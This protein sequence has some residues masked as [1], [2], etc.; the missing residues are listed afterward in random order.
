VETVIE[1]IRITISFFALATTF[2]LLSALR[3]ASRETPPMARVIL[4]WLAIVTVA[5]LFF[6]HIVR[7]APFPAVVPA[8]TWAGLLIGV[9]SLASPRV[10]ALFAA[11]DDRQ[12]R[13]L[14][15]LRAVFGALLLAGGTA[16][17]LPLAFA[18]PAGLGDALVGALALIVPGS[19]AAGGHRGSR[20]L[21]FGTGLIDFANVVALQVSVLV[22]WLLQTRGIGFSLLLPW[23]VL[24]LLATLN[25]FGMRQVARELGGTSV[26]S[27]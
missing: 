9:S 5:G 20:L 14:M 25:M 16:N 19:L 18:V 21:V 24:P 4:P 26:V 1:P 17:L 2:A 11:L 22:P 3:S 27:A 10:A 7:G 13:M 15:S 6:T 8:V 23:V 12:W